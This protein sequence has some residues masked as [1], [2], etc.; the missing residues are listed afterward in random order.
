MKATNLF[1]GAKFGDEFVRRDGKIARYCGRFYDEHTL[2]YKGIISSCYK[3]GRCLR[4]REC[5]DDIV[6]KNKG[7]K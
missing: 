4:V 3:D 2:E 6:A 1:R 5:P 7:I